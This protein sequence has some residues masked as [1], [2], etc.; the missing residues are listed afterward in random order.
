MR[1]N[2]LI[3]LPAFISFVFSCNGKQ[4]DGDIASAAETQNY[5][6]NAAENINQPAHSFESGSEKALKEHNASSE[7][8]LF[9]EKFSV[10]IEDGYTRLIVDAP[11]Q[12]SG[13]H[14][15]TYI[16]SSE[17]ALVPDSLKQYERITTPV[18]HAVI[19][20]TTF[21]PFIDTLGHKKSINGI[22]QV[23]N[24]YSSWI[25]DAVENGDIRDVGFDQVLNYEV[26]MELQPDVVFMFGVQSGITKN[27]AKLNE[28]GIK[29]V[30]VADYLEPHPLGRTEWLKFFAC[31][32]DELPLAKAIFSGITDNYYTLKKSVA[33][34]SKHPKI[35]I[36]LPWKDTWHI[37][38]SESF[39]AKLIKDAGGNYIWNDLE[40][41]EASQVAIEQVVFKSL[42]A[43]IWINIGVAESKE[44]ILMH[45]SRFK[46]LPAFENGELFNN[47]K[48]IGE[49][50]GNDYW[51]SGPLR[52]D[53]VLNDL[54]KIFHS[55]NPEEEGLYYYKR[56]N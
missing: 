49:L 51:E 41:T 3:I 50:G 24:Y 9:A 43:D 52:P 16:L 37:P 8:I 53:R 5:T 30:M 17:S 27:I 4:N 46:T 21:Y 22:S 56:L 34:F 47:N 20:S 55:I 40:G 32:Y 48:R 26:L 7:D 29:V 36:G 38:E 44:A 45:D 42:A 11:W 33:K 10:T 28:L 13:K 19:M 1:K 2:F 14:R 39:A 15:F 35:M 23:E 12:N 18:E 31:F 6:Q 54:V 25:I